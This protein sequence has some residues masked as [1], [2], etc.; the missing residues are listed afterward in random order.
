M[1]QP[2]DSPATPVPA[3]A[4]ESPSSH[5]L[6]IISVFSKLGVSSF[7][8]PVAHLGYFRA[9][10]VVKR[11]WLD[12]HAYAD[13]VAL[14]QLLPGP[15]SS[16]TAFGLGLRRGGFIGAVLASFCFTMPSALLM[17]AFAYAVNSGGTYLQQGWIH[18]LK[19]AAVAVVAQALRGMSTKLCPDRPRFLLALCAAATL[20]AFPDALLQLTLIAAGGLLGWL[21]YRNQF[22][23]NPFQAP[24]H[25]HASPSAR[26]AGLAALLIYFTLLALSPLAAAQSGNRQL[27]E[28]DAFYRPGAL[29]FGGGHVILP[30]LRAE[31]VPRGWL[32]DSQFL[33][34]YGAA[35]ALPG[36]LNTI[37]AYVGTAMHCGTQPGQAWLEGLWCLVAL[38]LPGWLVIGAALPFWETLKTKSWTRAA[39]QGA[40]AAVVGVL[41]A[42]LYNPVLKQS[43]HSAPDALAAI[44]GFALLEVWKTPPLV[45]VLGLAAA[46]QWVLPVL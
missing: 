3:A 9:E 46:G 41:L 30:L 5:W 35:Q 37:S 38:F 12:D 43:V 45:V 13:L 2:S 42:A 27:E 28:F 44:F 22:I 16:Q 24:T 40:N 11:R 20:T 14:C 26:R 6:E 39:L 32:S 4:K 33:A 18:G 10:V 23:A 1:A 17:I 15:A 21:W 19:L 25:S 29:V 8:G 31:I 36:P 7:G 34:G